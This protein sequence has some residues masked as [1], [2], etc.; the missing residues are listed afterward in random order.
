MSIKSDLND[1]SCN[2]HIQKKKLLHRRCKKI[3]V[4]VM[5]AQHNSMPQKV[6]LAADQANSNSQHSDSKVYFDHLLQNFAELNDANRFFEDFNLGLCNQHEKSAVFHKI[7]QLE[8]IVNLFA[9]LG[10]KNIYDVYQATK[11]HST[12]NFAKMHRFEV[13]ALTG[14]VSK[15]TLAVSSNLY[16]HAKYEKF[17]TCLWT[18]Q[19]VKQIEKTR[20]NNKQPIWCKQNKTA[21]SE[22]TKQQSE[23]YR[24]SILVVLRCFCAAYKQI[25]TQKQIMS[26]RVD[27]DKNILEVLKHER[28]KA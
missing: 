3:S 10:H 23:I 5:Q 15:N 26:V 4:A 20:K 11:Q 13:C 2:E 12:I 9:I 19:H 7:A 25:I 8:K 16:V 18:V 22:L 28:Q 17:I 6:S 14:I 24:Q 27:T 21:N 1:I